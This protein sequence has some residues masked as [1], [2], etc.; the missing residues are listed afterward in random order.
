M[1]SIDQ[2]KRVAWEVASETARKT[3]GD[4]VL[5]YQ[6][7]MKRFQDKQTNKYMSQD[8]TNASK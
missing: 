8:K 7:L 2:Y 1:N 5:L 4:P 3:G 6:R